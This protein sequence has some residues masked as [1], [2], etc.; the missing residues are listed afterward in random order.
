MI[1]S[2]VKHFLT[3]EDVQNLILEGKFKELYQEALKEKIS[4]FHI[5]NII[6]ILK[7]AGIKIEIQD[8]FPQYSNYIKQN[9]YHPSQIDLS[10]INNQL[11]N[12]IIKENEN[13][14]NFKD[15]RN[16]FYPN[17]I[18]I[19]TRMSHNLEGDLEISLIYNDG[20]GDICLACIC[21]NIDG[22]VSK[23]PIWYLRDGKQL[24]IAYGLG[25]GYNLKE[26]QYK[27]DE[28]IEKIR[29]RIKNNNDV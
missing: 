24:D 23:T 25:V 2:Y 6:N 15:K 18:I 28:S 7:N 21:T 11:K 1:S 12:N 9:L 16:D 14:L 20:V 3:K 10:Y 5:Q 29:D 19:K 4:S 26:I 22:Q 8:V 17:D 13:N 27:V